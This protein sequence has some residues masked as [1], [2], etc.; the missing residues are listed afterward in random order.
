MSQNGK[1]KQVALSCF[2]LNSGQ[3]TGGKQNSLKGTQKRSA[4]LKKNGFCL[5]DFVFKPAQT[6]DF[7]A[8]RTMK[9]KLMNC[10]LLTY[11]RI[12]HHFFFNVTDIFE[13]TKYFHFTIHSRYRQN[14]KMKERKP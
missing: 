3:Q 1:P 8:G 10:H 9:K 11:P 6:I 5:V 2:S 12:C 13:L 7:A 4:A 14:N